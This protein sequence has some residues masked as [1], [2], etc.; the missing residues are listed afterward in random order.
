MLTNRPIRHWLMTGSLAL[1]LAVSPTLLQANEGASKPAEKS[2]PTLAGPKIDASAEGRGKQFNGQN[3]SR[4]D[5][6][7]EALK[8]INLTEEQKKQIQNIIVEN[9]AA[10]TTWQK[11]THEKMQTLQMELKAAQEAQNNDKAQEIQKQIK[12]V[13]DTAPQASQ[14]TALIRKVLTEEQL[15]ALDARMK[16]IQESRRAARRMEGGMMMGGKAKDTA[17]KSKSDQNK[18]SKGKDGKLD[19]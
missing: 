18:Q 10:R 17:E 7:Q 14:T 12:A 19:L 15:T 3:R 11:A 4:G 16:E 1:V 2:K 5:V 9:R 6:T 8:S 13:R